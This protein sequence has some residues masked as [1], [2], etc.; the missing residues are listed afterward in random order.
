MKR[1]ILPILL[2]GSPDNPRNE[3][4]YNSHQIFHD[5]ITEKLFR[6]SADL[7]FDCISYLNDIAV[8]NVFHYIFSTYKKNRDYYSPNLGIVDEPKSP[9]MCFAVL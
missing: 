1:V 3:Q 2:K 4:R 6:L 7:V 8:A 5:K 9:W